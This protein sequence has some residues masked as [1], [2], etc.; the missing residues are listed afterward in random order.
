MQT[1]FEIGDRVFCDSHRRLSIRAW[2][3]GY[4]S[5]ICE[6][7][8]RLIYHVQIDGRGCCAFVE[9]EL[10]KTVGQEIADAWRAAQV[11]GG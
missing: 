10:Q 3:T 2:G 8:G 5:W 1:K 9:R 4:V 6:Y 11:Q 7:A